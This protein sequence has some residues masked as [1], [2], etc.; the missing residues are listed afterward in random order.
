MAISVLYMSDHQ[1]LC[2][3]EASYHQT[4]NC[5]TVHN[6]KNRSDVEIASPQLYDNENTLLVDGITQGYLELF[7]LPLLALALMFILPVLALFTFPISS[8]KC[9]GS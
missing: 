2:A 4:T 5:S 9:L 7:V 1:W 6:Y 8:Q 3:S